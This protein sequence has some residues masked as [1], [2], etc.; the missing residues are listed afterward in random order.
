MSRVSRIKIDKTSPVNINITCKKC[1]EPID[2]SNEFGMYC[3]NE[4]GIDEDKK[5]YQKIKQ[6]FGG[7]L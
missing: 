7:L 3:K 2:H 5:A 1:G 4:C 6:M